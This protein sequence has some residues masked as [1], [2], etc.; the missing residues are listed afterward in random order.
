MI[1]K[2][3]FAVCAV[4]KDGDKILSV[5]RKSS[6]KL[7]LGL[8]GGKVEKGESPESALKR[9]V[10]EETGL[11]VKNLIKIYDDLCGEDRVIT[12][13]IL[14]W[15]GSIHTN[16]NHIVEWVDKDSLLSERCSFKNYNLSLFKSIQKRIDSKV[17]LKTSGKIQKACWVAG[18]IASMFIFSFWQYVFIGL[19]LSVVESFRQNSLLLTNKWMIN[20]NENLKDIDLEKSLFSILLVG[21]LITVLPF[22]LGEL[23]FLVLKSLIPHLNNDDW[24]LFKFEGD[25]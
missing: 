8:P 17:S 12:Y 18:I 24:I 19:M 11:K 7:D 13:L 2:K 5:S 22:W 25:K 23:F 3:V 21:N 9:E 6:D 1:F 16:E 20:A 14:D 15:E 10:L 4:I